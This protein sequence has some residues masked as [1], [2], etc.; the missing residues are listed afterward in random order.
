MAWCTDSGAYS[1][2]SESRTCSRPSR[3]RMVLFG[4]VKR[5]KR[6]S[7]GGMG[8]RGRSSRYSCSKTSI[9]GVDKPALRKG[10]DK[11]ALRLTHLPRS[12]AYVDDEK[13]VLVKGTDLSVP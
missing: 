10:V 11:P 4:D 3:S 7:S 5:R 2:R 8:A 12:R 1:S 9:R 13:S 6:I